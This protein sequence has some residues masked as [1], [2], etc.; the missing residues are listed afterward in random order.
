[1]DSVSPSA[2]MHKVKVP[3]PSLPSFGEMHKGVSPHCSLSP[4]M[5]EREAKRSRS[6]HSED[7]EGVRQI[8]ERFTNLA[9][10]SHSNLQGIRLHSSGSTVHNNFYSGLLSL[11]VEL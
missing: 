4:P 3:V 8:C 9:K 11:F 5:K 2:K 10:H 7:L 6:E 1:M